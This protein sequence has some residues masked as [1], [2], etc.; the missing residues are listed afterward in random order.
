MWAQGVWLFFEYERPPEYALHRDLA[1]D[2][3]VQ[4]Q[5]RA[6][7]ILAVA[8]FLVPL[9]FLPAVWVERGADR[10]SASSDM[11]G[12][13]SPQLSCHLKRRTAGPGSTPHPGPRALSDTVL[14]SR[15]RP[16]TS[17][18]RVPPACHDLTVIA[19]GSPPSHGEP[20]PPPRISYVVARLERAVRS[21]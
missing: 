7:P 19:S 15:A 21:L 13:V 3:L 16:G 5:H 6:F 20:R 18:V 2:R 1:E 9:A 8:N 10:R 11:S 17:P 12:L 4:W 14:A